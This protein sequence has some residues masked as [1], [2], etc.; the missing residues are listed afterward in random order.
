MAKVKPA[1]NVK[2]N[3]LGPALQMDIKDKGVFGLGT[4]NQVR[5]AARI[6]NPALDRISGIRIL[7]IRD[8]DPRAQGE[9]DPPRRDPEPNRRGLHAALR[10]GNRP[11]RIER[12]YRGK[13]RIANVGGIRRTP[14]N[15]S[16]KR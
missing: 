6:R 7:P 2:E 14:S 10:P 4:R 15:R 3:C 1:T 5:R 13:S 9:V 16:L 12:T 8:L 11:S